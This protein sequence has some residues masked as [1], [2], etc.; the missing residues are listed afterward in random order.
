[1]RRLNA[2]EK[3]KQPSQ[4]HKVKVSVNVRKKQRKWDMA[5]RPEKYSFS[6]QCRR[7]IYICQAFDFSAVS[8]TAE[9][10]EKDAKPI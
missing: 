2:R 6:I 1:M 9:K 3:H 4:V 7:H 8:D 10:T 5:K